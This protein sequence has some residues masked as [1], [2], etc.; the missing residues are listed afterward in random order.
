VDRP[1][2][3]RPVGF[4]GPPHTPTLPD[5]DHGGAGDLGRS[6]FSSI[7][8]WGA[9]GKSAVCRELAGLRSKYFLPG[10]FRRLLR[11]A[12][13]PGA[14]PASVVTGCRGAVLPLMASLLRLRPTMGCTPAPHRDCT[15]CGGLAG[16]VGAFDRVRIAGR[17]LFTAIAMAGHPCHVPSRQPF[18][19]RRSPTFC[20]RLDRNS[21]RRALAWG[22]GPCQAPARI[23]S[24]VDDRAALILA[25][26]VALA[27]ARFG[28]GVVC[29]PVAYAGPRWPGRRCP[30]LFGHQLPLD[31]NALPPAFGGDAAATP[32]G[33]ECRGFS[34]VRFLRCWY[35]AIRSP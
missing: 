10:S 5:A 32:G 8:L 23:A 31:R 1:R 18:P 4:L 7:S 13:G 19:G 15:P 25:L 6:V 35:W 17:V 30:A 33:H 26:P 29:G 20:A 16:D 21:S 11:S 22:T 14:A 3:H 2:A 12:F 27:T 24:S 28:I 9:R 34:G